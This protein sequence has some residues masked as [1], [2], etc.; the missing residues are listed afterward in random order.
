LTRVDLSCD[1]PANPFLQ[2]LQRFQPLLELAHHPNLPLLKSLPLDL[3]RLVQVQSQLNLA[4][5][6]RRQSQA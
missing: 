1:P 5:V 4:K 3:S 6:R 2:L